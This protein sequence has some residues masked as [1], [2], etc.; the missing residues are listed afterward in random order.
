MATSEDDT[1]SLDES[2]QVILGVCSMAKKSESKPMVEILT[3]LQ[4]FEYIKTV[5]FPE[6]VILNK[7]VEEWPL[8]DCLV[9]FHSK[10][11]PLAKAIEYVLLRE[12]F[13]INDMHMQYDIQDR[14]KVYR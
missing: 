6:Q 11:F 8:C 4:E 7:P 14:R 1:D 13:V 9:S 2:K 3:R 10:G 5:V 12:P